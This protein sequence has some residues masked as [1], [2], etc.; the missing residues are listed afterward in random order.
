VGR[1]DQDEGKLDGTILGDEGWCYNH[2]VQ[3]EGGRRDFD[4]KYT[5]IKNTKTSENREKIFYELISDLWRTKN[6]E[7]G[8]Q[9]WLVT[10]NNKEEEIMELASYSLS[11]ADQ[12][13]MAQEFR[14]KTEDEVDD[15]RKNLEKQNNFGGGG[16]QDAIVATMYKPVEKKIRPINT[17][18][19][20]NFNPPLRRVPFERDPYATPLTPNPPEFTPTE[21]LTTERLEKINLG[22]EGWLSEEERKLYLHVLSLRNQALSF[23]DNERG[24]L[25]RTYA[26]P[27]RFSTIPHEP[28]AKKPIPIP[29]AIREKVLTL[30]R[31]RLRTGL[32]E[33]AAS[34]PYSSPWFVVAKKDGK[35]RAVHACLEL[36]DISFKD[37]GLPPNIESFID[38]FTGLACL[39]IVDIHGGYDQR[40]IDEQSR[41]LSAFQTPLGQLQLTRLPQGYTN[42][43]PEF[44]R[45][46]CFLLMD[47]IPQTAMSFLDDVA[48]K[49]PTSRY[50][51]AT[52]L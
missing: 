7:E 29:P 14:E 26:D 22:P 50:D 49:G 33:M 11:P 43:V 35:L 31:E 13:W 24:L 16:T 23:D 45:V 46:M 38:E 39:S 48:V 28:W 15:K 25:K 21:W 4:A 17:K 9:A 30:I 40:E 12:E 20:L 2:N 52:L 34:S 19:P 8:D 18:G 36:N 32:Y 42:S 27:Y 47:E 6:W 5:K 37:A 3:L 10:C 44:Q 41:P 1:E 51:G